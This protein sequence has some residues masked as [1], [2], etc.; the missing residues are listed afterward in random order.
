MVV[1]F[2][3]PWIC[4]E[5]VTRITCCMWCFF[6]IKVSDTQLHCSTLSVKHSCCKFSITGDGH[7]VML[8]YGQCYDPKRDWCEHENG[9]LF[10]KVLTGLFLHFHTVLYKQFVSK[11]LE[12]DCTRLECMTLHIRLQCIVFLMVH[13][14]GWNFMNSASVTK[15]G[16]SVLYILWN[17]SQWYS[18]L[19]EDLQT[20]IANFDRFHQLQHLEQANK[21]VSF[22]SNNILHVNMFWHWSAVI[23]WLLIQNLGLKTYL[24][25]YVWRHTMFKYRF[26][27]IYISSAFKWEL[28]SKKPRWIWKSERYLI[29]SLVKHIWLETSYSNNF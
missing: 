29:W 23:R 15:R 19:N 14:G 13:S 25:A 9:I 21:R 6:E 10:Y 5:I 24:C 2:V 16:M 22:P 26:I 18:L 27:C 3:V 11:C 7:P 12:L 4:I 17:W 8:V 20:P 28:L 1:C